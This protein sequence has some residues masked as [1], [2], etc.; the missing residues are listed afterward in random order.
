MIDSGSTGTFIKHSVTKSLGLYMLPPKRTLI[1]LADSNSVAKIIGQVVI[2]IEINGRE[3]RGVVAEVIKNLC[4]DIIIGNDLLSKHRRVIINYNG[5]CEELVIGAIPETEQ[6]TQ[7]SP[8]PVTTSNS[9]VPPN[10]FRTQ[11]IPPPPLFTNLTE[12]IKPIAT[13]SRR[14]PQ[15]QTK[16]INDEVKRL[17]KEGTIRPSVSPWRAQAFVTTGDANHKRRMVIDY[18]ETINLYTELDAYPMPSADKMI[19]DIAQYKFFSTFDLKSAYH[20]VPIQERDCKYTAFEADGQLWEFTVIP[21]GVTNGVSAFQRSIDKVIQSEGLADSF[22]FVDNVTVC[23]LT[24]EEHDKNVA[25]F[26]VLKKKYNITLND[27]KT[28]SSVTSVDV[29]GHTVSYN[30]ISPDQNRL[31]PLLEMPPPHSLKAQ[32]RV[33]GMFSYY[34][35]FIQKFSDKISILNKNTTFPVPPHVLQGFQVLK[36]DLKEAAL[37]PIDYEGSFEVETDASDFC[38]AATLNQNGR[39]VAFFSRT[40]NPSEINHPPVEKEAAAIVESVREWRHFLIGRTFQLI[41]DQKSVSFMYDNRRK[42][43]IK[44]DK[45]ARWRV[46]LSPYKFSI[47]YRPGEENKAPDTFS[48]IASMGHPLQELHNLHNQLCHP[49]VTRLSHFVRS[50]NLPFTQD[51]V[52][53][54]TT[55]CK[56]CAYLK[57]QFIQYKGTLIQATA[58]LQRLSVDFKGPLPLSSSGNKYL[59]TIIDEYSRFPF[60]YACRD[61]TSRTVTHCFNHLFSIFGMPDMVHTDRAKDFLSEETQNFLFEKSIAT[62]KT[63]RYN[64]RCNGQVEKLNGTL[65]KAIQ[66][67]LHSRNLKASEWETVLPDALHSIRSLLCTSTN[68]TPHERMFKYSRKSTSGNSVPS[69]VKPGPIFVKNHTRNSKN[70]PPVSPA[71]LLHANPQYAHVLLPSGVETT[72]SIRDLAH[73]PLENELCDSSPASPNNY[74]PITNCQIA[75]T[76]TDNVVEVSSPTSSNVIV[77]SSPNPNTSN[78][79]VVPNASPTVTRSDVPMQSK[80]PRSLRNLETYNKPGLKEQP[81]QPEGRRGRR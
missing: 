68:E 14:Q 31:R 61:M 27:S 77:N 36:N 37:K 33:V 41:T 74:I 45:I 7:Y 10:P 21:F 59:L 50:R 79:S 3:H 25:D 56:S 28:I 53:S 52:R 64:P 75:D 4:T 29:L 42:C 24:Q 73:Y 67:T 40:L 30:S 60:A 23:G 44:N 9:S 47:S 72:V 58:P 5:P 12:N 35:K 6:N 76:V 57:P 32:K 71:T 2:N 49:G 34:S 1:P 80:V 46:E 51:Q 11:G 16:F 66:V 48:R 13:K 39:P 78:V 65:W 69:W 43:K 17:L 62:S 8:T 26:H 15:S 55:S 22:A 70:N 18:S 19:Q 20:Q 63:S 54:M 81:E 38:I